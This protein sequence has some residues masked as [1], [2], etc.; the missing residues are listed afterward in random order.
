MGNNPFSENIERRL[1]DAQDS[2]A[3][4]AKAE[5][6]EREKREALELERD[7]L[8]TAQER[9]RQ[10]HVDAA[11]YL[12]SKGIPAVQTEIALTQSRGVWAMNVKTPPKQ[13]TAKFPEGWVLERRDDGQPLTV[14]TIDGDVVTVKE[15]DNIGHWNMGDM[16]KF[17]Y[18][19][20]TRFD[21][22][23]SGEPHLIQLH[24]A[25]TDYQEDSP[26]TNMEDDFMNVIA[27]IQATAESS[28]KNPES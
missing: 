22:N 24:L 8:R 21:V 3:N 16:R 6:R 4:S 2:L 27:R 10:L 20:R 11:E 18:S 17:D 23:E 15:S 1:A 28:D 13:I 7:T 26:P 9:L 14:L 25:Y 5:E 19:S 12:R